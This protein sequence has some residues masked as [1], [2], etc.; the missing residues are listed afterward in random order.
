MQ[1]TTD[2][3]KTDSR[4]RLK[5]RCK[6]LKWDF[7]VDLKLQLVTKYLGNNA[8]YIFPRSVPHDP[9]HRIAPVLPQQ[10]LSPEWGTS[11]KKLEDVLHRKNLHMAGFLTPEYLKRKNL[12]TLGRRAVKRDR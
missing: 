2:T 7:R 8:R 3:A 11:S 4:L 1:K 10:G 6:P 5:D 12:R 9:H